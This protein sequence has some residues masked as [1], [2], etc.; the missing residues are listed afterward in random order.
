[1]PEIVDDI[2]K[3]KLKI[4]LFFNPADKEWA[5]YTIEIST[6]EG[7]QWVLSEKLSLLDRQNQFL[8]VYYENE[9][10]SFMMALENMEHK[11]IVQYRFAPI[12]DRDFEIQLKRLDDINKISFSFINNCQTNDNS[13]TFRVDYTELEKF[14][15]EVNKDYQRLQNELNNLSD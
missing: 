2:S 1:M 15:R 7:E 10:L 11:R 8:D 12:D 5:N 6:R 4:D 9:I 3:A 14:R 13:I